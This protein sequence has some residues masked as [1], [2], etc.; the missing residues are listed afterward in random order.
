MAPDGTGNHVDIWIDGHH[1]GGG[2]RIERRVTRLMALVLAA[3]ASGVGGGEHRRG[4]TATV[5]IRCREGTLRSGERHDGQR[6]RRI[7]TGQRDRRARPLHAT[8]SGGDADDNG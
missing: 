6:G 1:P 3:P 2:A 8:G 4:T 7:A 5:W